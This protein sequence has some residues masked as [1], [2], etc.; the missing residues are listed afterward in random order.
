[1]KKYKIIWSPKAYKDLE[2]IHY[3]IEYYLKEKNIANNIV[4]KI[5]D[6]IANLSYLPEKYIKI[7]YLEDETKNMRKMKVDNY[8]VIYEINNFIRSSIYF[9]YS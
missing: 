8:I 1:M 4:K 9:T 6:S 3:Y 7:Q 5:L 2:N